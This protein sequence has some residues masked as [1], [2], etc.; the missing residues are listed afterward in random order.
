MVL[1]HSLGEIAAAKAAGVFSLE[2]GLR[3]AAVRGELM[4]ATRS[5]GAM[6]AIFA[7]ASRVRS[8][9]DEH[10]AISDDVGL[11]IAVD[12]G[13]QQVISGPAKEVEAVIK[14]FESEDI[15][16]ARLKRSPAYHSALVE[17]ATG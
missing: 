13:V 9:V 5:D 4:G 10:N 1:G 6:A 15:K 17:P 8:V 3:Y 16:V 14:I 12:N 2:Q 11:C 7:P